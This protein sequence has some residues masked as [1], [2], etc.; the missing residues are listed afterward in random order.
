MLYEVITERCPEKLQKILSL[1][2]I[3]TEELE[4]WQDV[5]QKMYI[6]PA[7]PKTKVV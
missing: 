3:T 6:L 5:A 4:Y 7:D 2:K 1:N